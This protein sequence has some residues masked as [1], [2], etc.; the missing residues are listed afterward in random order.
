M[1]KLFLQQAEEN[2]AF[3]IGAGIWLRIHPEDRIKSPYTSWTFDDTT[4]RMPEFTAPAVGNTSNTVT[5]D[6][7]CGA[8]ASGVL[9]AWAAPAA[10]SPVIWTRATSSSNTT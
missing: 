3:P 6:L 2:K 4:T 8:D 7:E 10:A 5:I 1:K 9:Y